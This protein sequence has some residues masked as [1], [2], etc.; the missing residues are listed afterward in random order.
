MEAFNLKIFRYD[1]EKDAGPHW[2]TFRIPYREGMTVLEAL[3]RVVEHDD[4]SLA[5]RYSCREAICGSCAMY[6]SGWYRLACKTQVKD[7]LED[8]TVTVSPL[9][10]LRVI[11]DLVVDMEPFWR[12]YERIKPYLIEDGPPPERERLQT[13]AERAQYAEMVDCILCGACYTSCPSGVNNEEYLGPHALLWA[14]RFYFDSRDAGKDERLNR[15]ANENGI[16]RC[17]TAFN[18]VETCP[19]H[20]NQTEAIQRLKAEAVKKALAL[21]R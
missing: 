17:H 15:V 9:P 8:G 19:K 14:A 4:P 18:C 6:I 20:L 3:L 16:F 1:P 7:A 12:N 11:K 5:M 13:P 21:R 10:H 2:D